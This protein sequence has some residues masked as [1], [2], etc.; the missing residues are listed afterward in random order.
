MGVAADAF[1]IL[2]DLLDVFEVVVGSMVLELGLRV[3]ELPLGVVDVPLVDVPLVVA[4]TKL[5][6]GGPGKTYKADVLKI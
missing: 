1:L 5:A 6:I 2:H 3:L 4:P